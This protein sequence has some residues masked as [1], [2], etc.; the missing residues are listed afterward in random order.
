VTRGSQNPILAPG[1][2]RGRRAFLAPVWLTLLGVVVFGAMALNIWRGQATT[3]VIVLRHAEKQLGAIADAPLSPEGA[4]RAESLARLF[5]NARSAGTIEA[6]YVSDT[7]RTRDTAA[8]LAQLLGLTPIA[9][10]ANEVAA[11]AHEILEQ[12][13]G[14]V[15]MVVGH[16]NTVPTLIAELTQGRVQVA[17]GDNYYGQVWIVSRPSFGPAGLAQLR[18]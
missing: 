18:F 10:D 17:I 1:V 4:A 7:R 12:Q 2:A 11:L 14:R 8:P 13:R 15:V 6:I 5:G 9:R 16:S 3:T